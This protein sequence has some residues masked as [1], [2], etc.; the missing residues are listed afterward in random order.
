M[1]IWKYYGR[2]GPDSAPVE[3][4][5]IVRKEM[6]TNFHYEGRIARNIDK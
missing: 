5:E 3:G 4:F 1:E 6:S 2:S